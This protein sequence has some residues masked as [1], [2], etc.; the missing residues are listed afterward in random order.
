MTHANSFHT[1]YSHKEGSTYANMTSSCHQPNSRLETYLLKLESL[2]KEHSQKIKANRPT[3][4]Q[5]ECQR[6][7]FKRICE[8]QK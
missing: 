5:L 3:I 7:F 1:D 4:E 8:K 2:C 6:R